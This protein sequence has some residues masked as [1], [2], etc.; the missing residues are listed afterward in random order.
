MKKIAFLLLIATLSMSCAQKKAVVTVLPLQQELPKNIDFSSN[1]RQMW[2]ELVS[3]TKN[4]E[5][6]TDYKPSKALIEKYG[7]MTVNDKY[8]FSGFLHVTE[9]FNAETFKSFGGTLVKFSDTKYT[10][11]FPILTIDKI[12]NIEGI[13]HIELARKLSRRPV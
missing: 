6:M 7:L 9:S 4:V 5:E 2:S 10:F 12:F 3:E 11:T 1:F 13:K 8:A